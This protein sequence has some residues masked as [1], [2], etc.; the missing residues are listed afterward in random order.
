MKRLDLQ[1][2]AEQRY[3]DAQER[4]KLA[5]KAWEDAGKPLTLTHVNRLIGVHPL[6]KVLTDAELHADKLRSAVRAEERVHWRVPVPRPGRSEPMMERSPAA[7]LRAIRG[8]RE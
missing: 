7:E 2:D 5:S 1:R 4:A 6:L 3:R 8:G